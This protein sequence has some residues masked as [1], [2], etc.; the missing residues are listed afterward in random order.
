MHH[1]DD[2]TCDKFVVDFLG[3]VSRDVARTVD[4]AHLE[5]FAVSQLMVQHIDGDDTVDITIDVRTAEGHTHGASV[6]V[7]GHIA[8]NGIRGG[9]V[10]DVGSDT[11]DSL[12]FIGLGVVGHCRHTLRTTIDT[13]NSATFDVEGDI[14][15]DV[16]LVGTAIDGVEDGTAAD[17]GD[18]IASDGHLVAAA[19]ELPDM[20]VAGTRMVYNGVHRAVDVALGVT[21]AEELVDSTAMNLGMGAAGTDAGTRIV[22]AIA[23]TT[24]EDL[25]EATAV[26]LN[27]H[28]IGVG[29]ITAAIHHTYGVLAP[30]HYHTGALGRL[31]GIVIGLM[32]ATEDTGNGVFGTRGLL[33][34]LTMGLVDIDIRVALG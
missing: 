31:T 15:N 10:L 12:V 9:I 5:R 11:S 26:N 28:A 17:S 33:S 2:R 21:A 34:R 8:L 30:M 4:I 20:L 22:V 7:E 18:D 29:S 14:A 27:A 24:A 23:V 13:A 3:R 1:V 25:I 16:G 6:E 32:A 19:K